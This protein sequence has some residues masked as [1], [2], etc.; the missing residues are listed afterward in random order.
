MYKFL[1]SHCL[2]DLEA[3]VKELAEEGYAL[4]NF[5]FTEGEESYNYLA[6][7]FPYQYL[8]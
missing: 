7:T 2:E 5:Q 8:S 6:Q 4:C 1:H 3:Q